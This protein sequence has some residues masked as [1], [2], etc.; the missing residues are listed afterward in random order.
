[1]RY[2]SALSLSISLL[3]SASLATA[4]TAVKGSIVAHDASSNPLL[5]AKS[6][7]GMKGTGAFTVSLK[8]M[9][10]SAGNPA[11]VTTGTT[12]DTQYWLT[13]RGD[14]QGLLWQ[15]NVPFSITKAGQAKLKGTVALIS[16]VPAGSA[17]GVLGVEVHEP[18][19]AG[20]VAD[21]QTLMTDPTLPG[22]FVP[23]VS[24]FPS[25]PCAAG[26]RLGLTGILTGQ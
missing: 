4:G 1:M 7:Y 5:S 19:P 26:A 20:S 16:A 13:V 2:F 11:P 18:T 24:P 3:L 12:P 10:N 15:Y 14:V 17:I 23:G 6:S 8:G 9:T 21:C 25:N 22:V